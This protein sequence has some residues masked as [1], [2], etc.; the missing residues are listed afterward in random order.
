MLHPTRK[1]LMVEDRRVE[2]LWLWLWQLQ[3]IGFTGVEEGAAKHVRH[4]RAA[5]EHRSM[6]PNSL[7]AMT[8]LASGRRTWA[9][10]PLRLK[11]L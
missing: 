7:A 1:G 8:K 6:Y 2:G 9:V 11:S 3:F 5:Q 4:A 10:P